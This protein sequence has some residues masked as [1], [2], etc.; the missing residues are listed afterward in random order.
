[1]NTFPLG[2]GTILYFASDPL[3][4]NGEQVTNCVYN[5]RNF[6]I[7][8]DSSNSWAEF[9]YDVSGNRIGSI[10]HQSSLITT[11]SYTVNPNSSLSQVLMRD[12][13]GQKTF[14][15]YGL[16]LEYEVSQSSEVR[17]YHY[18]QIGSTVALTD[19][20]ETVTDRIE[21]SP[22]GTVTHRIGTTDT[23]FLYVGEYGVQTDGNGLLYMR[24]RYYSPDIRRF[25]NSDP[26]RFDG[27]YNFFAYVSGDPLGFIDPFGLVDVNYF[28]KGGIFGIGSDP[29]RRWVERAPD[30]GD[31]ITV[32][33][34]GNSRH[35]RDDNTGQ[36][37]TPQMLAQEITTRTDFAA[38]KVVVLY[39]CSTGKGVNSFAS[40]L[41][42]FLGKPVIA[43][44]DTLWMGSD[45]KYFVAPEIKPNQTWWERLLHITPA[46]QPDLDH[47]GTMDTFDGKGN[48][49]YQKPTA[50][51]QSD[52]TGAVKITNVK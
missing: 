1:V 47:L 44:S 30:S 40:Q 4:G 51:P 39:S 11:N 27:G 37:I 5:T 35:G 3:T 16:G 34:H 12:K 23:P 43:P 7:R 33:M 20:S 45:G 21:Y 48:R 31:R 38:T 17:Y 52:A 14:Y 28:D 46:T 29:L 36:W 22:Y 26:I 25:L 10:T 15:V 8:V 32:G 2:P 9:S 49:I 6:L 50:V 24:A 41:A 42:K 18:D 19:D 13:N